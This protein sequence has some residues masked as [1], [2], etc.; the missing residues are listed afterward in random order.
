MGEK[1]APLISG[2]MRPMV[3]V[4]LLAST[5]AAVRGTNCISSMARRT[6]SDFSSWTGVV[7]FSTRLTVAMETPARSATSAIVGGRFLV[8]IIDKASES[9]FRKGF[10]Q[11]TKNCGVSQRITEFS[12]F[13]NIDNL[14]PLFIRYK[15]VV[16]V[17]S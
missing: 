10:Q 17:V 16:T 6:R 15:K 11:Y 2:R 8:C 7:P 4:R 1:N 3:L 13:G 14:C 9:A 5:R 12:S